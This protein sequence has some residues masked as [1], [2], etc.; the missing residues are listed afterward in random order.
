M[1]R[2]KQIMKNVITKMQIESTSELL[3][4]AVPV[5]KMNT[6][7][8]KYDLIILWTEMLVLLVAS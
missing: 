6:N 5:K 8:E 7:V 4:V 2:F 1:E 3:D